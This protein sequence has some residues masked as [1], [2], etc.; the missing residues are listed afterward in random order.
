MFGCL[1]YGTLRSQSIGSRTDVLSFFA[2]IVN[3]FTSPRGFQWLF[4]QL[5]FLIMNN[6]NIL[7]DGSNETKCSRNKMDLL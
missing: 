1:K 2:K 6:E 3:G 5:L 7:T 4:I